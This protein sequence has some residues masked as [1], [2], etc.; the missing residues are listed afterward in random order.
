AEAAT[1]TSHFS[2]FQRGRCLASY[3]R[4]TRRINGSGPNHVRRDPRRY[5]GSRKW[6]ISWDLDT[7]GDIP[8][9]RVPLNRFLV[10]FESIAPRWGVCQARDHIGGDID[11]VRPGQLGDESR[12]FADHAGET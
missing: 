3:R 8:A 7:G 12:P 1:E 4:K 6:R 9:F 10:G 5:V 11:L 2:H